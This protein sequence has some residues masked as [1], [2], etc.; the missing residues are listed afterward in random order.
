MANNY[1]APG[2]YFD[3]DSADVDVD[4]LAALKGSDPASDD[5][6]Y[7]SEGY[8]V[9]I[10]RDMSCH[11]IYH[12]DNQ[13]GTAAVKTGH[14]TITTSGADA[15]VTLT[16]FTTTGHG[17]MVG[18]GTTSADTLAGTSSTYRAIIDCNTVDKVSNL[19][20]A[21]CSFICDYGELSG[22]SM[23]LNLAGTPHELR[24][25]II[26]NSQYGYRFWA[27]FAKPD[28]LD[29]V[30]F[31]GCSNSINNAGG[32]TVMDWLDFF[33]ENEIA[34]TGNVD[35]DSALVFRFGR[36]VS[37]I[38]RFVCHREN[39]VSIRSVPA[40]DTTTGIQTLV[41][42]EDLTLTAAWNGA[43]HGTGDQVRYRIYI[44]VGSAPDSFDT[45]SV[46]FL[47]ETADEAFRIS[48]DA[49]GDVLV[50][51]TEY[52]VIVRAVT[53]WSDED[54]NT[55]VLNEAP[56]QEGAVTTAPT[57]DSTTGIQSLTDN[58]RMCILA[59][60][61]TATPA[62]ADTIEYRV[63]IRTGAAPD[64]F[65]D[66]SPY[67]LDETLN[68]EYLISW[69][70]NGDALAVSTE[71]YVIVK[72]L[73]CVSDEDAN[74]VALSS[75]T[76]LDVPIPPPGV[77]ETFVMEVM[78]HLA[79]YIPEAELDDSGIT[80][81]VFMDIL[82]EKPDTAFCV[83]STGGDPA[84]VKLGYDFPTIHIIVRATR[85]PR[86]SYALALA[87]YDTFHGLHGA[88]IVAGGTYVVGCEGIQSE[89]VSIGPDKNGRF[90]YSLNF[91]FDISRET[92]YR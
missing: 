14:L 33:S 12:G 38:K 48:A 28:V 62:T 36:A 51:D 29:G 10:D 18:E 65:G 57:W 58:E 49:A 72:A 60:W 54:T 17:G 73:T 11:S 6:I 78:R 69:D 21:A 15:S 86:E 91:E 56:T 52:Y 25:S 9:T 75:E 92:K 23:I 66:A 61:G 43:T 27:T 53:A 87:V 80:G 2:K 24:N 13:A 77:D 67:L 35:G 30:E 4:G 1:N 39:A 40:W 45:D 31:I 85:D 46:Y 63:Y 82:P 42:N 90:R 81:N 19:G 74:V 44:R 41:D 3:I 83:R 71:Y 88:E 64:S 8:R 16:L 70:E 7:I 5:W 34:L 68:N 37:S 79:Y 76:T 59:E 32:D 20:T 50:E 89:P 26:R 55:T 47:C 84:D 22:W